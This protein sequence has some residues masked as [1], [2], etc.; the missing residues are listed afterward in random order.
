MCIRDSSYV[1]QEPLASF[2]SLVELPEIVDANWTQEFY[3]QLVL[4]ERTHLIREPANLISANNWGWRGISWGRTPQHEQDWFEQW[5]GSSPQPF[6]PP[7]DSTNRYLFT[8]FM[9]VQQL[10]VSTANRNVIAALLIG[11]AFAVGFLFISFDWMRRPFSIL[12]LAY[13]CILA[14]LSVPASVLALAPPIVFGLCL[15]GLV[16]LLRKFVA[17]NVTRRQ[18]MRRTSIQR[19]PSTSI[20]SA[21]LGSRSHDGAKDGSDAATTTLQVPQDA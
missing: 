20:R 6:T 8:T 15:V 16:P 4:P 13:A 17:S 14:G 9:G 10:Y 7:I 5:I 3:W 1:F 11:G 12:A 19:P 18:R 2:Q 21:S